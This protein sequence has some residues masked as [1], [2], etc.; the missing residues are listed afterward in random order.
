MRFDSEVDDVLGR[1]LEGSVHQ[2]SR[3][4]AA[5]LRAL[6]LPR[7]PA[8]IHIGV[9]N[10]EPGS[11]TFYMEFQPIGQADAIAAMLER[12]RQNGFQEE[13]DLSRTLT[14]RSVPTYLL[15]RDPSDCIVL[16]QTTN[17]NSF[18]HRMCRS[19]SFLPRLLPGLFDEKPVSQVESSLLEAAFHVNNDEIEV[20]LEALFKASDLCSERQNQ[21]LH[22]LV[23]HQ[24]DVGLHRV[25]TGILE[26]E[27]RAE[28]H[29]Q[30]YLNATNRA[31]QDRMLAESLEQRMGSMVEDVN[32]LQTFLNATKTVTANTDNGVLTLDV[33]G[34]LTNFDPDAY[35]VIRDKPNSYFLQYVIGSPDDAKL[36]FDALFLDEIIKIKMAARYSLEPGNGVRG[37]RGASIP[38]AVPNPHI[39]YYSCLGQY[40]SDMQTA[41]AQGDFVQV[42]SLC[43]ASGLSLNIPE[44]PTCGHFIEDVTRGRQSAVLLPGGDVATYQQA[45]SWLKHQKGIEEKPNGEADYL[46]NYSD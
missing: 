38:N 31:M 40:K 7:A 18:Q 42:V 20:Q 26:S 29:L 11:K 28:Q 1:R 19:I 17:S 46:D 37:V 10:G 6:L 12:H 8:R 36:F 30:Q 13:K 21:A 9:H 45:V 14:T 43:I 34:P 24:L 25:R 4:C 44:S 15:R 32:A 5:I 39:Q 2:L 33:V 41:L 23:T 16:I 22:R 3:H 27:Q 35:R